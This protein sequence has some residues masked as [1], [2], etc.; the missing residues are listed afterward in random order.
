MVNSSRLRQ[1]LARN[2]RVDSYS[3]RF[4][5]ASDEDQPPP[6]AFRSAQDRGAEW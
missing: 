5:R 4:L 6:V 1:R 3:A 2:V